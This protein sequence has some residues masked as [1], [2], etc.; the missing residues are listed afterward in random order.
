ML[1]EN[2]EINQCMNSYGKPMRYFT[3][4]QLYKMMSVDVNITLQFTD[5]TLTE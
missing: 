1:W 2:I 5:V 4:G 3:V